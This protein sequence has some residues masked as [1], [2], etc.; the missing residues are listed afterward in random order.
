MLAIDGLP[1]EELGR[2]GIEDETIEIEDQG[3]QRHI[4]SSVI[5]MLYLTRYQFRRAFM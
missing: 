1:D 3:F 2:F 5:N 4:F